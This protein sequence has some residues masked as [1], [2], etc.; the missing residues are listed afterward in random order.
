MAIQLPNF[1]N[2]NPKEM[3]GFSIEKI[4]ENYNEEERVV[5]NEY[6]NRPYTKHYLCRYW[7]RGLCV[8]RNEDCRCAHG[9]EDLHIDLTQTADKKDLDNS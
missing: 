3:F 7:L 1:G 6:M 9:F 2:I 5:L 8:F 4:S